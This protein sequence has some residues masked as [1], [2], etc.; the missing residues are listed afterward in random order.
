MAAASGRFVLLGSDL[1]VKA[2]SHHLSN[3]D[4]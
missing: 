4:A 2:A 1:E 3:E